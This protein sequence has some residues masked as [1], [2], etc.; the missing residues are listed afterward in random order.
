MQ[1][2]CLVLFEWALG[3]GTCVY[4]ERLQF[5]ACRRE[6]QNLSDRPCI[7]S[8]SHQNHRDIVRIHRIPMCGE[9]KYDCFYRLLSH[10]WSKVAGVY[11]F[12]NWCHTQPVMDLK[13]LIWHQIWH[14]FKW[15]N[16]S[17]F[18]NNT[19]YNQFKYLDRIIKIIFLYNLQ[20]FCLFL[21][22]QISQSLI[23]LHI[24]TSKNKG[25]L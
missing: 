13:V 5:S 19:Q 15:S 14:I 9:Y 23:N 17:L 25:N 3:I 2:E 16:T 24:H 6:S 1:K 18:H 4:K 11:L 22:I 7:C 20:F 12:P 10:F 8:L 21:K